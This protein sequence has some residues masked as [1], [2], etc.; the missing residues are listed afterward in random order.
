[1]KF[2]KTPRAIRTPFRNSEIMTAR[3]FGKRS[4]EVEQDYANENLID[5]KCAVVNE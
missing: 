4:G 1:M 3:G 5:S 2:F